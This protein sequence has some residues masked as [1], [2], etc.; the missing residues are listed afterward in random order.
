MTSTA[1]CVRTDGVR[2]PP[3][4]ARRALQAVL[5]MRPAEA[6]TRL[7]RGPH[8]C[9]P[10]ARLLDTADA[11]GVVVA[12]AAVG[13]GT[14]IVRV[15]RKAHGKADWINSP[16]SDITITLGPALTDAVVTRL[17][18]RE[19]EPQVIGI[20]DRRLPDRESRV[21]ERLYD[22]LDPDLG[23]N[24]VDFGFVRDITVNEEQVAVITMTLTSPTC[25][26]TGVMTDQIRTALLGADPVA[27]DFR[28][29]WTWTPAWRPRDLSRDGVDQLR[30]I[31][32]NPVEAP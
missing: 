28:I 8:A 11:S 19:P 16:T 20:I 26:V 14:D 13:A 9:E 30:A 31:G 4:L 18:P 23:I 3:E 1:Q 22:V 29:D 25:P 10:L 32:F 7:R 6:A 2:V 17:P 27:A 12:A 24:I 21:L 5:G 15:R